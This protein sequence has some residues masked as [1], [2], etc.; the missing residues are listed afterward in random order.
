MRAGERSVF[1]AAGSMSLTIV[2]RKSMPQ[3]WAYQAFVRARYCFK[4]LEYVQI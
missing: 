4:I 2:G 1:L 3:P